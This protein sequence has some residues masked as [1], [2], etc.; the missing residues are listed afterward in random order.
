MAVVRC[1]VV[2]GYLASLGAGRLVVQLCEGVTVLLW[3]ACGLPGMCSKQ[4]IVYMNILMSYE[5]MEQLVLTG[6]L[7]MHNSSSN[8][9]R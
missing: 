1:K 3:H 4:A 5:P 8:D 2:R 6:A 9:R 7:T